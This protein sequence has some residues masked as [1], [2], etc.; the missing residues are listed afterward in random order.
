MFNLSVLKIQP[1]RKLLQ[2]PYGA[3]AIIYG[4]GH[5]L[6]TILRAVITNCTLNTLVYIPYC[7]RCRKGGWECLSSPNISCAIHNSIYCTV[8]MLQT[9]DVMC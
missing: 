4:F 8:I 6:V 5:F 9:T 2:N 7:G 1:F 3:K